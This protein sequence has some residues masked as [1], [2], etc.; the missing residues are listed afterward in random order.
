MSEKHTFKMPERAQHLP[1]SVRVQTVVPQIHTDGLV[2]L[3]ARLVE[4]KLVEV[5]EPVVAEIH[6]GDGRQEE[7]SHADKFHQVVVGQVDVLKTGVLEATNV[8]P[9]CNTKREN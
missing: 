8:Q 4:G 6:R 3:P 5:V 9:V 7:E 1:D 2:L